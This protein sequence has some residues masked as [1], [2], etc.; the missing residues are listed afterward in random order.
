MSIK[1]T[2]KDNFIRTALKEVK[3]VIDSLCIFLGEIVT[4]IKKQKNSRQEETCE[5]NLTISE[6]K[7]WHQYVLWRITELW[8]KMIANIKFTKFST[9]QTMR[10]Q[11]NFR[12]TLEID[13]NWENV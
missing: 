12:K 5:S 1:T 6:K 2:G 11:K 9:L 4:W 13:E 7:N 3:N 8:E 10:I